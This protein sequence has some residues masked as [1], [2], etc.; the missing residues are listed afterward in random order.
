MYSRG[1]EPQVEIKHCIC[2]LLLCLTDAKNEIWSVRNIRFLGRKIKVVMT[3]HVL[4][5]SVPVNDL[6][7]CTVK[8]DSESELSTEACV[9]IA[10]RK[11]AV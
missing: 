5:S 7:L 6:D 8:I 1:T 3:M 2:M 9:P 4:T 10:N 11:T